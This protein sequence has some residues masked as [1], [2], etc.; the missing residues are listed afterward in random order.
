[1]RSFP[2]M[3]IYLRTC[4]LAGQVKARA[5]APFRRCD[6]SIFH[7]F[8]PPPAGGGH[9]FLQALKR[10]WERSGF[11][12]EIN[13]IS[14]NTQACL[15]NSF[16]FDAD[17][18]RFLQ[19]KGCRTIHR[20]DGPMASYRGFD[21]GTDRKI[22]TLSRELADATIFQSQYSLAKHLEL[23]FDFTNPTII[24]NAADPAIFHPQGRIPFSDKRKIRLIS[25]S[26]SDN[27]NK[28]APVYQWLDD[29][30]DWGRYEY[31]FVGRSPVN[32][33]NIRTLSPITSEELAKELR[34]HDVFITASRNDPCSNSLIEAL[35]CGLP[36]L[37]LNSGGHPE[38]VGK[39]GLSFDSAEEIPALLNC[40]TLE[41]E[42]R[43]VCIKIPTIAATADRYLEILFGKNEISIAN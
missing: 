13:S 33:H 14:G 17:R 29:H 22:W 23:G 36:A 35:S 6:L 37:Y 41:Y 43:Q 18:F 30:L 24:P 8:V 7:D 40:L 31:T 12:V 9:Q 10:E 3:G 5:V 27:V 1:M 25:V 11:R 26:W 4:R 34:Q 32:F 20:V 28:G 16:N 19:R 39:A 2:G 42:S 21:D 15:L 38:I